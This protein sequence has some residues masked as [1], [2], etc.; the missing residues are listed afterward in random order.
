MKDGFLP[1]DHFVGIFHSCV[2]LPL[3]QVE[4]IPLAAF[5]LGN[6]GDDK[7]TVAEIHVRYE[8]SRSGGAGPRKT[9]ALRR[10]W[11]ASRVV[12]SAPTM[13]WKLG[14]TRLRILGNVD[15]AVNFGG[16][17][18]SGLGQARKSD[19][20]SRIRPASLSYASLWS[21]VLS[22][23]CLTHGRMMARSLRSRHNARSSPYDPVGW[24]L[25]IHRAKGQTLERVKVN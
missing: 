18:S 3:L 12:R 8:T 25:S 4:A 21:G 15:A 5:R 17:S 13:L 20:Y 14:Y 7:G 1:L 23:G 11:N 2:V 22:A 24:V 10:T 9:R 16:I 6:H 19:S